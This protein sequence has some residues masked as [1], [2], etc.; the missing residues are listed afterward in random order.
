MIFLDSNIFL[1]YLTEP[2]SSKGQVLLSIATELISSIERGQAEV[3]TS[4]VVLHEVCYVLGSKKHYGLAADTIAAF[5]APIL[6]LTN[7]RLPRGEKSLYLR[8]LEIFTE[9]PK[10]EFSD[11]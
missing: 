6:R 11:S 4:E 2:A 3:T 7:L 1:R 8:A 10:L 9:N 5:L